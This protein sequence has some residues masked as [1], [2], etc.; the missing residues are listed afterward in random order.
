MESGNNL[1]PPLM[2]KLFFSA[3]AVVFFA[4]GGTVAATMTG[5]H[6]SAHPARIG[7]SFIDHCR[8]QGRTVK[9]CKNARKRA[10]KAARRSLKI[11]CEKRGKTAA[12]CRAIGKR[13]N[14]RI[15]ALKRKKLLRFIKMIKAAKTDC[16]AKL[17]DDASKRELRQCM[18]AAIKASIKAR[19]LAFRAYRNSCL[20]ELSDDA[21]R[22]ELKAC[23]LDKWQAE[24][25]AADAAAPAANN[26]G[27]GSAE[28]AEGTGVVDDAAPTDSGSASYNNYGEI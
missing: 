15:K 16:R 23:I 13:I 10:G 2:K 21:N 26:G 17:G 5:N 27:G 9:Q 12:E 18:K 20:A 4:S 22:E 28:P 24:Q 8:A 14:K 19:V 25:S 3:I 11:A 7:A 1:S 6:N